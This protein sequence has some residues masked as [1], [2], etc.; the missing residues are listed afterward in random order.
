MK[1]VVN[2][3]EVKFSKM[4]NNELLTHIVDQLATQVTQLV[5]VTAQLS[6][7]IDDLE[8]KIN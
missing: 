4:D 6:A 8:K 5:L 2:L 3:S 7:R 1:K